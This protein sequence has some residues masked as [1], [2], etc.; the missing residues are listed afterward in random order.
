[1]S[2]LTRPQNTCKDSQLTRAHK[3]SKD[4]KGAAILPCNNL[5]PARTALDC[6]PPAFVEA[7]RIEILTITPS[8]QR[9]QS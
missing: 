6:C 5:V 7:G 9:S 4:K 1:M 2:Q 3:L 8:G